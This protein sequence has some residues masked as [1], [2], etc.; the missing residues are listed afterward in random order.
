MGWQDATLVKDDDTK[1]DQPKG[2]RSAV[3]VEQQPAAEQPSLFSKVIGN[4]A[5]LA[6]GAM[7]INTNEYGADVL[8]GVGLTGTGIGEMIPGLHGPAAAESKELEGQIK[9][10][11]AK[12]I[13]ETLPFLAGGE[14]LGA[15]KAASL[16]PEVAE[17]A[18]GALAGMGRAFSS[19]GRGAAGGAVIAGETGLAAPTGE[20]DVHEMARQKAR[21]G[22]Q[23]VAG[24]AVLGGAV[25]AFSGIAG[26]IP[27]AL[28]I[29]RGKSL[30]A[31][32][33]RLTRK[34]GEG[35]EAALGE[36]S[37]KSEAALRQ[38]SEIE[39]RLHQETEKLDAAK[40]GSGDAE[41]NADRLVK[42]F[43]AKPTMSGVEFGGRVRQVANDTYERL[44]NERATQSGYTDA[45]NEAKKKGAIVKTD[46]LL[47]YLKAWRKTTNDPNAES[48]INYVQNRI[49]EGGK[50]SSGL[51]RSYDEAAGVEAT[52]AKAANQTIDKM[53]SMRKVL[54][55]VRP[56][57]RCWV[58]RPITR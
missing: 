2:W 38:A 42:E 40:G 27:G 53:D 48:V 11:T 39:P 45:I 8:R 7:D 13:G 34:G 3:P 44:E 23:G 14:W 32:M 35:A 33:E 5:R 19:M 18:E 57:S 55:A 43:Q 36:E 1:S 52:E 49:A 12:W 54:P 28:D 16:V 4:T 24:G 10:P 58:G 20:Q 37:A 26:E 56:S 21:M 6:K 15:G 31:A 22:L 41:A 29:A 50:E 30:N 47:D 25:G 17:G 9:H 46:K 51:Q